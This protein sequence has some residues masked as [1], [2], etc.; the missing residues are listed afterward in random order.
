MASVPNGVNADTNNDGDD[1]GGVNPVHRN[2]HNSLNGSGSGSIQGNRRVA[3]SRYVVTGAAPPGRNGHTATLATCRSRRRRR[4]GERPLGGPNANDPVAMNAPVNNG[5]DYL[6]SRQSLESK[7]LRQNSHSMQQRQEKGLEDALR[8]T[9][10]LSI[11]P[12]LSRHDLSLEYCNGERKPVAPVC[13]ESDDSNRCGNQENSSNINDCN[14]NLQQNSEEA[15]NTYS[16][17]NGNS[18]EAAESG[19]HRESEVDRV[20]DS[21]EEEFI[22]DEEDAQ[23]IIIGGWLG[24]GPLAASDMWVLDISGGLERLRWFQPVSVILFASIRLNLVSLVGLCRPR[25]FLF[26]KVFDNTSL[27]TVMFLPTRHPQKQKRHH[28]NNIL[29]SHYT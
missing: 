28:I 17:D 20:I 23:I 7:L 25:Y 19:F 14:N 27:L 24:S 10:R 3:P 22:N 13:A 15:G 6:Q 5:S 12:P 16:N 8:E 2:I 21:E 4:R 11:S 1:G 26:Y 18:P 29:Q 9:A